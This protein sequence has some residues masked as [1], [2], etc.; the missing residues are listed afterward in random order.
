VVA[1]WLA[2]ISPL[3]R[4]AGPV[5]KSPAHA[6]VVI[7]ED[8]AATEAFV[9]QPAIVRILVQRGVMKFTGQSNVT[10][11][12]LS[13]VSTQDVIGIKVFSLPGPQVGT[14]PEVVDAVV[15]GLL[16]ARVPTNHVI[17][18]DQRLADLRRAGF[19]EIATK[20]GVRLAGALDT[21]WDTNVFYESAVLGQL[22][23]GDF[24]YQKE[25]ERFGRKSF[26]TK[27]LTKEVTKIINVSPLLNHNSAGVCGTL[28]S[29]ALGSADNTLRF[30][31][32][33][34][35]LAEAV[36][37]IF[38]L[39][40]VGEHVA[41]NIVDALVCQYEG[42]QI[43][44]LH[45]SAALNQVRFS[46]DPVALDVLSVQ[47]IIKQRQFAELQSSSRTNQFVLY[48][49]AALIELGIADPRKV[50]VEVEKASSP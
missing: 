47:E 34:L 37:D 2:C 9:P 39:P 21:G 3:L 18:W 46:K 44:R 22:I 12:W 41:L 4:A 23:H 6:R 31:G 26:V 20:H 29:L 24:E 43:G 5:L 13:I 7:V 50:E 42:E 33:T 49:N 1:L 48:R 36:P 19:T 32:N 8:H 11:A 40:K 45:N 38:N 27:L 15:E 10:A 14:K 16:A 17:I 25:G 28:Y 35:K 30:E